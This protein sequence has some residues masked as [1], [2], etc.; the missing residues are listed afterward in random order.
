MGQPTHVQLCVTGRQVTAGYHHHQHLFIKQYY[1]CTMD[2]ELADAVAYAPARRCMCTHQIA[3]L[4]CVK[5]R[6]GR[7]L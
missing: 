3:T 5:W 6:H 2:Q 4:F 1:K 7:H